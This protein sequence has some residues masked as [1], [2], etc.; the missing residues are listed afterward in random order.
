MKNFSNRYMLLYALGLAAIVALVLTIVSVSLKPLQTR[1]QQAETKQMILKTIGIEATL[2]DADKLY[3]ERIEEAKTDAGLPY[4]NYDNGIIIPLNG[5]GLWGPIWGYIALGKDLTVVGA[6]FDHKGETPGLGGEIATDNFA[7]RFIGKEW[8]DRPI[9][10]KKNAD[11]GNTHE[12]DAIS[13]GTMTSNGVTEMLAKA[14]EEYSELFE[15]WENC[16]ANAELTKEE[17]Q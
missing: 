4:Y 11:K 1:N 2:E 12:V 5:N 13:G 9:V 3:S 6:V 7:Q 15:A 16:Q 8:I 10:L 14:F 17:Q